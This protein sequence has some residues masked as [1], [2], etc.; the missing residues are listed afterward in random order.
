MAREIVYTD[1]ITGDPGAEPVKFGWD[2]V[3]FEIDLTEGSKTK[4]EEFLMPYI[5]AGHPVKAA[6][7]ELEE[8]ARRTRRPRGEAASTGE[9][10]SYTDDDKFGQIHRGRLT[11]E[12]IALVKSNPDQ[13]S[14]NREAQ[15]H[16]A[17]DWNDPKEKSRYSLTDDD[18]ARLVA[19]EAKSISSS[20]AN[21]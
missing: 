6:Q 14:R 13:A 16:P 9:K 3:W 12:E 15:G 5:N 1:D 11:D 19:A 20:A 7:T 2:E 4:L 21:A 10:V 8:P 17:I 18:V